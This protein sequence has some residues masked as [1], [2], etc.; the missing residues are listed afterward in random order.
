MSS[1]DKNQAGARSKSPYRPAGDR[2]N[3]HSALMMKNI[4][5]AVS[6]IPPEMHPTWS[7]VFKYTIGDLLKTDYH[8]IRPSL[9]QKTGVLNKI[10][11]I[12][13]KL[14]KLKQKKFYEIVYN[15]KTFNQFVYEYFC[16]TEVVQ[17]A[18]NTEQSMVSTKSANHVKQNEKALISFVHSIDTMKEENYSCK[19]LS[20]IMC[21]SIPSEAV[22][23]LIDLRK[24]IE[25]EMGTSIQ[26]ML[27]KKVCV[28]DLFVPYRNLKK[29]LDR[30]FANSNMNGYDSA[31]EFLEKIKENFPSL[32]TNYNV[33][34]ER[35]MNFC[36]EQFCSAKETKHQKKVEAQKAIYVHPFKE[37]FEE[38]KYKTKINPDIKIYDRLLKA[39]RR[40]MKLIV[41]TFVNLIMQEVSYLDVEEY[42][43]FKSLIRELL[44]NKCMGLVESVIANNREM[45]FSL[46]TIEEP[47][48]SDVEWLTAVGMAWSELIRDE[49]RNHS[50][51]AKNNKKS[52]KEN[53]RLEE[54]EREILDLQDFKIEKFC[55]MM[56]TNTK[57]TQEICRLII[58]LTN[59]DLATS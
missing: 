34:Y 32:A 56:I 46:L 14:A 52:G 12:Y 48:K 39:C 8:G 43:D 18:F 23:F 53:V 3:S 57:M 40:K 45:W 35:F 58:Y 13:S 1:F 11:E 30:M 25:E 9:Q 19:V 38:Y 55:K 22:G 24:I 27:H 49:D 50:L 20:N 5:T 6:A 41:P 15:D 33:P 2:R 44:M 21:G 29:I 28:S 37:K 17:Q 47:E 16:G 36:V 26:K 59:A 31:T 54:T 51:H 42:E 7:L 4:K 10:E